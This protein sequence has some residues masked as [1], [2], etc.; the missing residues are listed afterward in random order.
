MWLFSNSPW[1]VASAHVYGLLAAAV[2]CFDDG[3]VCVLMCV[4]VY[5]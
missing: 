5:V 3:G 4:S 2:F 1:I